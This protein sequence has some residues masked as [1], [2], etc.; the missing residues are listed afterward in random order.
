MGLTE[1]MLGV[2]R[3][4]LCVVGVLSVV[5]FMPGTASGFGM[6]TRAS[7]EAHR[8][9]W[10]D[11]LALCTSLDGAPGKVP[12]GDFLHEQYWTGAARECMSPYLI[13]EWMAYMT[14]LIFVMA[15]APGVIIVIL[16]WRRDDRR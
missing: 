1:R 7:R 11:R 5:A 4:A 15:V 12:A 8:E 14:P 3:L 13:H 16:R 2:C 9:W 6:V 10:N